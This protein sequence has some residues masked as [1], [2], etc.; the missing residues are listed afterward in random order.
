[1]E[2]MPTA[3]LADLGIAVILR[4]AHVTSEHR[5]GTDGFIA[6]EVELGEPYR[7]SCDVFSLGCVMHWL[8]TGRCPFFDRDS[9]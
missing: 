4:D 6:P 7:F 8:L 9:E 2:Q 5:I 1:M 3:Y